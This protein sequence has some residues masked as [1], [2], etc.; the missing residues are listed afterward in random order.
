MILRTSR[1]DTNF[2]QSSGQTSAAETYRIVKIST[3]SFPTFK[4]APKLDIAGS[5]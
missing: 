4:H 2:Q 5:A 3:G 1:T